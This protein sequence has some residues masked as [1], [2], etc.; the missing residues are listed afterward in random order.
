MENL[1]SLTK[2]RRWNK[3]NPKT[4]QNHFPALICVI[5]THSK[6]VADPTSNLQLW[7]AHP[8]QLSAH[9]FHLFHKWH[10][11]GVID[12]LG[13]EKGEIRAQK[14]QE[15]LINFSI[16]PAIIPQAVEQKH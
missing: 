5:N 7:T 4:E 3:D 2:C 10:Q 6:G 1:P 11:N 8:P 16:N 13:R 12:P 15:C 9:R 14:Q